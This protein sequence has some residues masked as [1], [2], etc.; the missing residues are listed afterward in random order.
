MRAPQRAGADPAGVDRPLLAGGLLVASGLVDV[1]AAYANTTA[2][3]F[4]V[5]T[6]RGVYQLDITGWA[7]LHVALG[8]AV[9]LAG[10]LAVTG[11]RG[12]AATAIG[13]AALAV[14]VDVLLFP[15]APVRALFVVALT[16][17]AVRLLLRRHRAVRA[18]G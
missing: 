3:P 4:M 2:D 16:G 7:W 5:L 14:V 11:R 18:G 10:L 13:C 17:A 9:A 8:A 1:V 6:R 12:T 15:Y